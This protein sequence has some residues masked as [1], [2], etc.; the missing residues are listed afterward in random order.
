MHVIDV[1]E[2]IVLGK[3]LVLLFLLFFL[4][5]SPLLR[6]FLWDG[7]AAGTQ[8]SKSTL[9]QRVLLWKVFVKT[10][11]ARWRTQGMRWMGPN[12]TFSSRQPSYTRGKD[13]CMSPLTSRDLLPWSPSL[14]ALGELQGDDRS[15]SKL[16]RGWLS[17]DVGR[18]R[19]GR[20]RRMGSGSGSR[21]GKPA[22]VG[23]DLHGAIPLTKRNEGQVTPK[24]FTGRSSTTSQVATTGKKKIFAPGFQSG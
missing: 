20:R 15:C 11:A 18:G 24:Y 8:Q 12:S 23:K 2:V 19:G 16:K 3:V 22:G 5:L 9:P 4:G 14:S 6:F 10:L 1:G 21:V 13:S 7:R 17:R